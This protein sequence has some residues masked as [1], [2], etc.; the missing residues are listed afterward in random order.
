MVQVYKNLYNVPV[1][2]NRNLGP[3]SNYSQIQGKKMMN[4]SKLKEIAV[5]SSFFSWIWIEDWI[6]NNVNP[7]PKPCFPE[8]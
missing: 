3:D 8:V 6:R 1:P 2:S 4:F 5:K 7:A